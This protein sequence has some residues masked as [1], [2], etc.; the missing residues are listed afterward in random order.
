MRLTT[1]SLFALEG[2]QTPNGGYS[3]GNSRDFFAISATGPRAATLLGA[4]EQL[5]ATPASERDVFEQGFQPTYTNYD[6]IAGIETFCRTLRQL[7][8]HTGIKSIDEGTTVWQLNWVEVTSPQGA[9]ADGT[10]CQVAQ[11]VRQIQNQVLRLLGLGSHNL[12]REHWLGSNQCDAT[13]R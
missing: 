8:K 6:G 10:R 1:R 9:E 11:A 2:K 13:A 7:S 5:R 4:A 12:N 3:V